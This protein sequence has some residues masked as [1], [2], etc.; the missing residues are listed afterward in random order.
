M[1]EIKLNKPT[2]DAILETLIEK[3]P[4][5]IAKDNLVVLTLKEIL[6]ALVSEDDEIDLASSVEGWH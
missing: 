3:L 1:T 4:K 6:H 5:G 2:A